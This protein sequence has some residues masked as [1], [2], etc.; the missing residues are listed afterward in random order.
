VK[1]F[2]KNYICIHKELGRETLDKSK[3]KILK[4]KGPKMEPVPGFSKYFIDI[5][6]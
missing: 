5:Y 3:T 1:E 4:N 2:E 6:R